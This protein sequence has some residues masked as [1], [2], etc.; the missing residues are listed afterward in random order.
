MLL[1][2]RGL[3]TLALA[4]LRRIYTRAQFPRHLIISPLDYSVFQ[5]STSQ[6]TVTSALFDDIAI[7]HTPISRPYVSCGRS[8]APR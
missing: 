1:S 7:Q 2:D 5:L 8:G 6:P 3:L 4:C